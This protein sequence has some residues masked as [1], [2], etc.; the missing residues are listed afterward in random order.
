[1]R[2]V[3]DTDF[4]CAKSGFRHSNV[5][6]G[7]V[8]EAPRVQARDCTGGPLTVARDVDHDW[9]VNRKPQTIVVRSTESVAPLVTRSDDVRAIDQIAEA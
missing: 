7:H 9:G 4:I 2:S 3:V 6:T 8:E 5:T 1:M